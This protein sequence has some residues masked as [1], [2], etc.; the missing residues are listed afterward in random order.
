MTM[1]WDIASHTGLEVADVIAP[2]ADL[3]IRVFAEWPYLY[4]GTAE[5]EQSYLQ[6]YVDCPRSLAIVVRD[7]KTV[8]GAS[9]GLPLADAPAEMQQPFLQAGEDLQQMFYCAESVVLPAYRGQGLG[10]EFFRRREAHARSLGLTESVFCAVDRS[11]TD[12]R[13]PAH[14][15]GNS[16]FWTRRG[17]APAPQHR[18]QFAWTDIGR[19]HSSIKTLSFWRKTLSADTASSAAC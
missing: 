19:T 4:A 5:Y 14:Y 6:A 7:G 15:Q 1:N 9:T 18:C 13:R 10:R 12:P 16:A 2:L 11:A 17:Y 3:R 8:I